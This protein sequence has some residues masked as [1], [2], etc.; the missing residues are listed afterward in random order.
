[1]GVRNSI[2]HFYPNNSTAEEAE[3]HRQREI[4]RYQY[5]FDVKKAFKQPPHIDLATLPPVG[6]YLVAPK[7]SLA[8]ET[9]RNGIL[10][11]ALSNYLVATGPFQR[12]IYFLQWNKNGVPY[13][14]NIHD[15]QVKKVA[16]YERL[17]RE[18]HANKK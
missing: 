10:P 18:H 2:P 17:R 7:Y 3:A 1:M 4:E 14:D 9:N 13:T 15:Y 6:S 11:A 8:D 5:Q 12:V 16:Y